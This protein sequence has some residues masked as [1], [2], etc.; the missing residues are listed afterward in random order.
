MLKACPNC[1]ASLRR[2]TIERT[3][4]VAGHA[5]KASLPALVCASCG[6]TYFA[7]EDVASFDL[8]V[9]ATL[10]RAGITDAEALKFMRRATGLNG[11]EFADLLAVR[12]ETV[13]RWEQG[14]RPID[15]STYAIIHQLVFD[16]LRGTSATADWLRSLRKPKRLPKSVKL[17]L[18][19]A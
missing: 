3:R 1:N 2:K 18:D 15:R 17:Q 12:P 11:K 9:A 6:E 16:R 10:A 5:F 8:H 14:R 4:H 7:D 19:A 13:S